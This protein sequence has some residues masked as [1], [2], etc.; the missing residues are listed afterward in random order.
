MSLTS[1]SFIKFKNYEGL[2][3]SHL[4][5]ENINIVIFFEEFSFD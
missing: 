3:A 1:E 5:K 4:D 2:K